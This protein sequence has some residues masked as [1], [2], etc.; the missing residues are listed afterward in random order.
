MWLM[1]EGL[2]KFF[3]TI[4]G[5]NSW[6][7]TTIISMFPIIELKGAIPVGVS[8][9]FW[10]DNALSEPKAFLFSL[11]GSCLVV[12]IIAL[13]FKPVI[14]YMKQTKVFKRVALVI[15]DK[16]KSSSKRIT[17]NSEDGG[18]SSTKKTILK[19]LGVF[20]FVAI[21]LPLTGVWTGTCIAVCLGLR[22]WQTV[23]SVVLGNIVAGFLVTT[24]CTLF[25][26]F[27]SILFLIVLAIVIV[28]LLI[29][30]IKVLTTKKT[31]E[32]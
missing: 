13:I 28:L 26:N 11:L 6:L 23:L 3:V 31:K 12:P 20:G 10:G 19:M 17:I 27:T 4:F 25:P 7:A 29:M 22:F 32:E 18:R 24:V 5:S 9:E 8:R 1:I 30:L 21:P 16:V 15:E 14:S 2:G